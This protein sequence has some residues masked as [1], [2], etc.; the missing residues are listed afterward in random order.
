MNSPVSF[1]KT[2][3]ARKPPIP[4]IRGGYLRNTRVR[5]GFNQHGVHNRYKKYHGPLVFVVW[6]HGAIVDPQQSHGNVYN[7]TQAGFNEPCSA[8]CSIEKT[9]GK[10]VVLP[11]AIA[12]IFYE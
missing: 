6:T 5:R 8:E 10:M 11:R 4:F 1:L 9:T 3:K 7:P 12:L 2:T